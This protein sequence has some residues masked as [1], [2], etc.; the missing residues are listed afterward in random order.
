MNEHLADLQR[1]IATSPVKPIKT[2]Q[3][4]SKLTFIFINNGTSYDCSMH[5]LFVP[6]PKN[7]YEYQ[8]RR[9]KELLDLGLI[10]REELRGSGHNPSSEQYV[11]ADL[12]TITT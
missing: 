6:L 7:L 12:Y 1:R 3:E 9:V 5:E 8:M 4:A 2:F 10:T 11:W